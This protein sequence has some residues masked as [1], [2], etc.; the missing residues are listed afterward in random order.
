[1]KEQRTLFNFKEKLTDKQLLLQERILLYKNLR[2][3]IKRLLDDYN[4]KVFSID[5]KLKRL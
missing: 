2:R 1:M 5:N 3:D 4:K